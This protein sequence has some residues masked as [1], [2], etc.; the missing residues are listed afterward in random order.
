MR[1]CRRSCRLGLDDGSATAGPMIGCCLADRFVTD[2]SDKRAGPTQHGDEGRGILSGMPLAQPA[3]PGRGCAGH[4]RQR[5]WI[6]LG[7]STHPADLWYLP[8]ARRSRSGD[9]PTRQRCSARRGRSGVSGRQSGAQPPSAPTSGA[10]AAGALAPPDLRCTRSSAPSAPPR[11]P[12]ALL[13]VRRALAPPRARRPARPHH[14]EREQRQSR[15]HRL[16]PVGVVLGSKLSSPAHMSPLRCARSSAIPTLRKLQR[17][18]PADRGHRHRRA[19]QAPNRPA[20][21]A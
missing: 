17:C 7:F 4:C 14:R 18:P 13:P 19:G 6:G 16:V 20:G 11:K 10:A 3:Q 9:T 21:A 5:L 8:S 12:L 2:R 15:S 1:L